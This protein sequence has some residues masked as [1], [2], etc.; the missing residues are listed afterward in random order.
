MRTFPLPAVSV[1]L[2]MEPMSMGLCFCAKSYGMVYG[3]T[4]K[5]PVGHFVGYGVLEDFSRGKSGTGL[6]DRCP[7]KL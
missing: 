4:S 1:P 2:R 3:R 7:D 6:S 5:G